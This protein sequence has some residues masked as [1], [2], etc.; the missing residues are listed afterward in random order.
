MYLYSQSSS[1]NVS[2]YTFNVVIM[3]KYR[4]EKENFIQVL[5]KIMFDF[6]Y[7]R[8]HISFIVKYVS[9]FIKNS[10]NILYKLASR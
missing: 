3:L 9:Q 2:I 10:I 6:F 4:K 1:V 5:S 8:F 7:K